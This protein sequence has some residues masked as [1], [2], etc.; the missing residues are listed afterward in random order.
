MATL[1]SDGLIRFVEKYCPHQFVTCY[2]DAKGADGDKVEKGVICFS[3][4]FI[5]IDSFL[6][7]L[8]FCDSTD[9]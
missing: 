2:N 3:A 6:R 1:A 4:Q 7:K 9:I 5:Y 8:L